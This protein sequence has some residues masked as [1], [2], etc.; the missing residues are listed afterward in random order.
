MKT[1]ICHHGVY[2]IYVET[3]YSESVGTLRENAVR[4]AIRKSERYA[5]KLI[6][7][8]WV[9]CQLRDCQSFHETTPDVFL[10]NGELV[11]LAQ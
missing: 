7:L 3:N 9:P 6:R 8:H 1:Q 5:G 10:R 2:N 4:S 11:G